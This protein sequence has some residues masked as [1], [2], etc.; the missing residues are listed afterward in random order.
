MTL[1]PTCDSSRRAG[2]GSASATSLPRIRPRRRDRG[3]GRARA[4]GQVRFRPVGRGGRAGSGVLESLAPRGG[5]PARPRPGGRRVRQ[6]DGGWSSSRL[7]A[8]ISWRSGPLLHPARASSTSSSC[9]PTSRSSPIARGSPP[10]LIGAFSRF[11]QWSQIGAAL[12]MKLTPE[13]VYHGLEGGLTRATILDRLAQHS[14]GRCPRAWPRP[15]APGP[16]VASGSR[17]TPRPP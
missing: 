12:E 7:W 14:A 9:S 5:L 10:M 3:R 4:A 15:C 2:I 1:P 11:A 17:T 13:S 6:P 16:T 8:A